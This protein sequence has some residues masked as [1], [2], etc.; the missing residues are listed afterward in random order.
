MSY[1]DEVTAA[2][3]RAEASERRAAELQAMLD[4]RDA[5]PRQ[6]LPIPARFRVRRAFGLTEVTWGDRFKWQ[7]L[8]LM[9]AFAI[10]IPLA[11]SQNAAGS[12]FCAFAII[13]YT[14]ELLTSVLNRSTLRVSAP[15]LVVERGPLYSRRVAIPIA[16]IT[17][18]YCREENGCW[19]VEV[20]H[21]DTYVA[22][23]RDL[24]HAEALFLEN[25]IEK[26]LGIVDR[27]HERETAL[28]VP[29]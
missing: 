2:L 1:R 18:A 7:L 6:N 9:A 29:A 15:D 28:K 8:L 20:A 14:P 21:G 23:A 3:A 16:A 11:W 12:V 26:E 17:Q 25:A 22:V 13:Y 10:F 5:R 27:A 24:S 4:E 19:S